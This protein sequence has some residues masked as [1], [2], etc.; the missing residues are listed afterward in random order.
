MKVAQ[1]P[2]FRDRQV[3][4]LEGAQKLAERLGAADAVAAGMLRVSDLRTSPLA[5][6]LFAEGIGVEVEARGVSQCGGTGGGKQNREKEPIHG[7]S[8]FSRD[9]RVPRIPRVPRAPRFF[10]AILSQR[11]TGC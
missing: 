2:E 9:S 5:A 6:R 8:R 1:T 7:F 11:R 10:S 4:T 3:R